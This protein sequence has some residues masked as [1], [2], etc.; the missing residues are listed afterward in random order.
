MSTDEC[1]LCESRW[2]GDSRSA[3]RRGNATDTGKSRLTSRRLTVHLQ[4]RDFVRAGGRPALGAQ[5]RGS[6]VSS[7]GATPAL[8]PHAVWCGACVSIAKLQ[9]ENCWLAA[10]CL[11]GQ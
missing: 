6:A 11:F 1:H 5:R 2:A 10:I 4:G 9:N 7:R 8:Q 3:A